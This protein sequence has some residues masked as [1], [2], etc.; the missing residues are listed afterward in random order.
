[1][2]IIFRSQ[3]HF[4]NDIIYNAVNLS[5][6]INANLLLMNIVFIFKFVM[7]LC[8]FCIHHAMTFNEMFKNFI[9]CF[10]KDLEMFSQTHQCNV[11]VNFSK[12]VLNIAFCTNWFWNDSNRHNIYIT[13]TETQHHL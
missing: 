7:F 11:S 3:M 6:L 8:L 2:F 1:M 10:K 4:H 9:K 12:Y 5:L 13:K